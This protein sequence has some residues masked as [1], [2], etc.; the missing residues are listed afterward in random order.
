MRAAKNRLSEALASTRLAIAAMTLLMVIVTAC[1]L[2]QVELGT[3]AAVQKHFRSFFLYASLGDWRIPVFPAGGFV[4]AVLVLNLAAAM[5]SRLKRTVKHAGLW[6]IHAGLILLVM[7]EFVTGVFSVETRMAIEEGQ[8][9]GFTESERESELVLIDRSSPEHDV[10]HAV[11]ARALVKGTGITDPR[12]PF[13]LKVP[14]YYGNVK[15]QSLEAAEGLS[16]SRATRGVGPR[17]AV[18]PMAPASGESARSM[19]AAYV[20]LLSGGESLGTWLVSTGLE[21]QSFEH[22]GRR[23]SIALRSRR[24]YLPFTL[25]LKDFRHDVYPGTRIPR[26]FSSLVRLRDPRRGDDR[27]VLIYMNHP[28]RHGGKAFYQASY[29]KGDTLS[30]LQVVENPGWLMP[31]VSFV[32]VGI[33]LILQFGVQV[34]AFKLAGGKR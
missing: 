11:R 7:G 10:V 22:G 28:L 14:S 24:E 20:E 5:A 26:N 17:L 1:T 31:Y 13:S 16:P 12:L 29:G 23:Y 4:G 6:L 19:P 8:T 25:T 2:D 32:L 33:G 30:I 3:Y 34:R 18:W 9:V 27:E 15:L 21:E